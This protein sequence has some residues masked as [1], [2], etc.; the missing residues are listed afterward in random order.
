MK[1]SFNLNNNPVA[2]K[3]AGLPM[4]VRILGVAIFAGLLALAGCKNDE[5]PLE[6]DRVKKML[7]ANTWTIQQVTVD[8]TDRTASFAELTLNF[9]STHYATTH[10]GPVWPA[11]DIW[12]FADNTGKVIV[13]GDDV[14]VT[15]QEISST[16]LIV[17]FTWMSTTFGPGRLS[18]TSGEH[19]FTFGI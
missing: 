15:I 1:S 7:T 5:A 16:K 8:G 10:G 14:E 18:S 13:R 4:I 12:T 19:V 17:A 2:I 3:G 9:T 6:T 11:S